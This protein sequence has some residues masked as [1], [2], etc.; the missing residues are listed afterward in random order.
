M[1]QYRNKL[2]ATYAMPDTNEGFNA[3]GQY[4]LNLSELLARFRGKKSE[5]PEDQIYS[6]LGMAVD[7]SILYR[8][9]FWMTWNA[10]RQAHKLQKIDHEQSLRKL[11][12]QYVICAERRWR[13][14]SAENG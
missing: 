14:G 2:E 12:R 3:P 9:L 11:C 5:R 13:C 10:K 8:M 7:S 4:G 6:I 1:Q